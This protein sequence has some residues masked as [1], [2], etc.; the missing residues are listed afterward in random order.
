[1][2]ITPKEEGMLRKTTNFFVTGLL[3]LL[4][5]ITFANEVWQCQKYLLHEST[6][7]CINLSSKSANE[8]FGVKS[9]PNLT[10]SSVHH[11]LSCP[12]WDLRVYFWMLLLWSSAQKETSTEILSHN[13]QISPLCWK[14]I[15]STVNNTTFNTTDNTDANFI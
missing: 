14:V 15:S 6:W 12:T 2:G 5:S 7:I 13:F 1:M 8:T 9:N 3:P 10:L 11:S 4:W